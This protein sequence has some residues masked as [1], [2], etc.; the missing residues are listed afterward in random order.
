LSGNSASSGQGGGVL[1]SGQ[2]ELY[3]TTIVSNTGGGV[4][5]INRSNTRFR[6]TVLQNP[7]GLNCGG[8]GTAQ[9][10]DDTHNFSADTSCVLQS[11]Q[12]GANLD[13]KLG[14]LT[15][16]SNDLTSF[17]LPLAGSPL[18]DAGSDCPALDQR[19][20]S[21]PNAC[22][23]GAVE[24][25]GLPSLIVT[26]TNDSGQGSLRQAIADANRAPGPDTIR[27]FAH[28]TVQL[29]STLLITD[30]VTLLGPGADLFAVD[31]GGTMGV[32]RI[33]D[34]RT[35]DGDDIT[36]PVP[37]SLADL[38]VQN[39][40]AVRGGG[41]Q[42][43]GGLTLTNVNLLHNQASEIGGGADVGGPV[44]LIGGRFADNT[45]QGNGGGL[46]AHNTLNLTGTQFSNNNGG[47][48]GGGALVLEGAQI[49]G[50]QFAS[51]F[52]R[53]AHCIGGG[54]IVILKMSL[55]DTQFFDNTATE[56]GGGV[57]FEGGA[58][59]ITGSRF[60]GNLAGQD[61]GGAYIGLGGAL[62][63]LTNPQQDIIDTQF[64]GNRA[65][66]GGGLFIDGFADASHRGVGF[67][68][69]SL[70]A[71]NRAP[72]GAAIA[73][74]DADH[75]GAYE[76]LHA[77]ID[78]GVPVTATAISVAG[79]SAN[80]QNTIL[81]NYS[82]GI[83]RLAGS[84]SENANLF[85]HTNTPTAGGV[86]SAVVYP[87]GDPLFADSA[88][89][90]YHLGAGSA[91]ID[92]ALEEPAHPI[93]EDFEG[94]ARPF[95]PQSDIGFDEYVPMALSGLRI[96]ISPLPIT[97]LGAQTN[98]AATVSAGTTPITYTWDFG[99]GTPVGT[100]AHVAHTYAAAGHFM[101]TLT[102]TN[103]LGQM[104]TTSQVSVLAAS[105]PKHGLYLP[106]IRH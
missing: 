72:E 40:F 42:N 17:H 29:A 18:I 71:H 61:G 79:G 63:E 22:D 2:V 54:L 23:I 10:S 65:L 14:P 13:P 62:D 3:S 15:Q 90:D 5:S 50:G 47:D 37:A 99:D 73:L 30:E 31:G 41:I 45:A 25:A 33:R 7:D 35:V 27:I 104:S 55:T 89:D 21:R 86:V 98:F 19:G 1:N 28:G 74:G 83:Q 24:F 81:A 75:G 94:Q 87:Q 67:V 64:L 53:G 91:A 58:A 52:C 16:D 78:G 12:T 48:A 4:Y 60:V 59:R 101:V 106:V 6:D 102:A 66:R 39:G 82:I 80:V 57:F 93:T 34:D 20:A 11:S 32:F 46:Y 44:T 84:V 100:G 8:D 105:P 85:F 76:I 26:N 56:A 49:D 38:T 43:V 96:A 69:N 92:K 77:T 68:E 36:L 95:G 88:Q 97:P 103:S 9:I 51:N 70:F